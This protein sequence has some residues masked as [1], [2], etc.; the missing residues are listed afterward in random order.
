[1]WTGIVFF[2]VYLFGLDPATPI[3]LRKM[4]A[5]AKGSHF[6]AISYFKDQP[7]I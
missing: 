1:M 6:Y 4:A 3:E 2:W 5:E 7:S